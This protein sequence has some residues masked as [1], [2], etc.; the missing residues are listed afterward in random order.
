MTKS[1]TLEEYI[2]KYGTKLALGTC[3]YF[4]DVHGTMTYVAM[5]AC[6]P[7]YNGYGIVNIDNGHYFGHRFDEIP[8]LNDIKTAFPDWKIELVTNGKPAEAIYTLLGINGR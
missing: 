2:K 3:I 6:C 4:T 7:D 5:I 8:T 1:M